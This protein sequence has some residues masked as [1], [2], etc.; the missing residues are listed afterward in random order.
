MQWWLDDFR[1]ERIDG[2]LKNVIRTNMTDLSVTMTTTENSRAVSAAEK[3]GGVPYGGGDTVQY[4]LD[5]DYS[6]KS[7]P[8]DSEGN[9]SSLEP[10][11]VQRL[12]GGKIPAGAQ[13]N[14]TYVNCRAPMLVG[15]GLLLTA[16]GACC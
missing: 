9:F 1:L 14:I 5:R 13:V 12:P 16:A 15:G 3:T 10:F 6:I 11:V 8:L 7:S 2:M 4:K